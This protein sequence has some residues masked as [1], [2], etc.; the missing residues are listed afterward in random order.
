MADVQFN[1]HVGSPKVLVAAAKAFDHLRIDAPETYRFTLSL[2]RQQ[3]RWILFCNGEYEDHC[4]ETRQLAPMLP[5]NTLLLVCRF[6]DMEVALHAAAVAVNDRR[7]ILPAKTG[8]GKS[9]LSAAM[10][11]EGFRFCSDDLILLAGP[12]MWVIPASFCFV[13][14]QGSWEIAATPTPAVAKL[15]T[16][17]RVDG[18]SI[19]YLPPSPASQIVDRHE[20]LP[21]SYL[22]FPLFDPS[23]PNEFSPLT[24][25][26]ALIRLAESGYGVGS[27]LNRPILDRLI[28]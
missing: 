1:L 24:S 9:T 27:R 23:A 10:L 6:S 21:T 15:E 16:H 4:T 13:L 28:A 17:E 3:E 2:E 22:V 20:R 11:A 8:S 7:I 12:D 19:R 25:A 5:A 26:E 14:K 18:K